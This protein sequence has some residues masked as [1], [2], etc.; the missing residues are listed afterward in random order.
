MKK[1]T[2]LVGGGVIATH[3][4]KGFD[5]SST[6][7]LT[8]LVDTNP[9]CAAREL[10]SVPFFTELDDALKLKPEVAVLALPVAAHGRVA[11]EL[12]SKGVDVITEKPM[13]GSLDEMDECLS[14][15]KSRG[16]NL[17]CMFHWKAA[18]EVKF[19]KANLSRYGKIKSISARVCDDYAATPDG[20]IRQDRLGLMGAWIDSGINILSYFDEI[21][22]LSDARLTSEEVIVDDKS[23]MPKYAKKVFLASGITAEITVDWTKKSNKKTSVIECEGGTLFV[24]H[25]AQTVSFD[26][27][28][29]FDGAVPDRLSSHYENLFYS[30]LPDDTANIKSTILLHKLLFSGSA[31]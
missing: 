25:T 23:G 17:I 3:Y 22:D 30:L 8:A 11:R 1:S 6:L 9:S 13:F 26:G 14:F 16:K 19:L 27:K 4:V 5:N 15:A 28:I 24:D 10:F 31:K 29:I 7:A 2:V 20:S 18:D 12:L 21:L